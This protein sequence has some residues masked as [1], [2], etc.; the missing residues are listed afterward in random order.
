MLQFCKVE[1]LSKLSNKLPREAEFYFQA[2]L[3]LQPRTW[4]L[5]NEENQF[6]IF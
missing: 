2:R 3:G 4:H 5:I 1:L 6:K